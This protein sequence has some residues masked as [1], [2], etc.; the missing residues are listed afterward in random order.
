MVRA[1]FVDDPVGFVEAVLGAG[2]R[3]YAKQREMMRAVAA[4]RRVS[5]VGCNSSGKDWAAA[6]LV[7]WWIETRSKAKAVVTGPTH[8]Q[9]RQVVWREMRAAFAAASEELAGEMFAS[10][11][12]V[13]DQRFAIG[14]ATND[15]YN[16]QGFHSPELLVVVTEAHAVD[17]EHIEAL[18]RLNPKRLLLTGNPLKLSGELYDSHHGKRD[19][20]AGVTI[21]A[22]DTPNVE[23]RDL[24]IPGMVTD[25][26][27]EERRRD[28]G[29]GD[30][31]YVASVLGQFPDALDDSLLSRRLIDE[32]V[33]RWRASSPESE[34]AWVMGVDVA[35][36]GSDKSAIVMRRGTRVEEVYAVQ[37][38]DGVEMA[39]EVAAR[40]ERHG[41]QSV[42]VD[43]I[44]VGS[45]VVDTLTHMGLSV[46]DV[47]V[48]LPATNRERFVNL[49]AELFWEL[50]RRFMEGQIAIP[51][52]AELASQLLALR[53]VV[54]PARRIAMEGKRTLRNKGLR[55]PDKADA[56][57]LAFMGAGGMQVWV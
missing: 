44:G 47:N 36:F 30:P 35:R 42:Y 7:L 50:R 32:A 56:L 57:A 27:V 37:G 14:F 40:M 46:T 2:G 33:E 53:Y 48:G 29:E 10:S 23:L 6:R 1:A 24:V 17:Q 55:S 34:Q 26:D 54:D 16:L 5:V 9:V 28:W 8:R 43:G 20:Y 21:S 45:G 39:H 25:E 19:L 51:D 22:F 18:K 38:R 52:D 49:R 31:L 11:Y 12:I 4:Y 41:V 15:A 3:P 13:D